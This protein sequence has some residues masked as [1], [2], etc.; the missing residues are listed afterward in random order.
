MTLRNLH[1]WI[2]LF[3]STGACSHSVAPA[4]TSETPRAQQAHQPEKWLR[5]G[6]DALHRGDTVRAEQ[7]LALALDQGDSPTKVLPW[8][9]QACIEGSRLRAALGYAETYAR[10]HPERYSLRYLAATI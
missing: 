7:Y 10:A 6:K 8:L 9:L 4:A 2:V 3:L 1:P 5:Q